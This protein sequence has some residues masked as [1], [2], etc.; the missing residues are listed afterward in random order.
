MTDPTTGDPTDKAS[1]KLVRITSSTRLDYAPSSLSPSEMELFYLARKKWLE[2][3]HSEEIALSWRLRDGDLLV[4][5][6]GRVMHGRESFQ[7]DA[8][9]SRHLVSIMSNVSEN[10]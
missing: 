5:D 10:C 7:N 8:N 9:T 3:I 6:N 4:V 1:Q 2:I